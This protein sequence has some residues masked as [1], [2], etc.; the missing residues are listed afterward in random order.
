MM[1]RVGWVGTSAQYT[2]EP[3]E[4]GSD[5]RGILSIIEEQ[6]VNPPDRSG[7]GE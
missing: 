1:V 2:L 5:R 7:V 3:L 6:I 4:K